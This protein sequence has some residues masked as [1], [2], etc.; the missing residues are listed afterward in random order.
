[1]IADATC[2]PNDD[3]DDVGQ[4]TKNYRDRLLFLNCSTLET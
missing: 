1:M 4:L 2:H 3:D